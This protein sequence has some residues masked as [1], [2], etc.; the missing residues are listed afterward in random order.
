MLSDTFRTNNQHH[1]YKLGDKSLKSSVKEKDLGIIVDD[2]M[3]FSEQCSAAVKKANSTLALI[4]RTIKYKKKEIIVRL[5]KALVRPQLEYCIQTWRP[6]LQTDIDRL[7]QVQRRATRMIKE[8]RSQ[9]YENRLLSTGLISLEARRNRGDLIQVFNLVKGIDK[10]DFNNF[11][12]LANSNRTRGHKYK[13]VKVRSRLEIRKNF[14]SNR[15]VN[16]WNNLPAFVVDADSVNSFKNRL[17][18]FWQEAR[19]I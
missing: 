15:I 12:T 18:K 16:M 4:R 17:D 6:Y 5:Y 9:D 1:K 14:F 13:L 3:K 2:K 10:I 8:C 11:F 19:K 7:E